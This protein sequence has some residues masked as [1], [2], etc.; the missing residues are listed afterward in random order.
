MDVSEFLNTYH[1]SPKIFLFELSQSVLSTLEFHVQGFDVR[2]NG[3]RDVDIR[4][5][6][7]REIDIRDVDI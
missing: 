4:D 7:F 2:G 6:D 3:N 5:I 1:P